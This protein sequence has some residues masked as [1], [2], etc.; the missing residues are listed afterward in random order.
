MMG[1]GRDI[2]GARRAVKDFDIE[3]ILTDGR[4]YSCHSFVLDASRYGEDTVKKLLQGEP[5]NVW[6]PTGISSYE[7]GLND[8]R[9]FVDETPT[10]KLT[11]IDSFMYNFARNI[12]TRTHMFGTVELIEGFYMMFDSVFDIIN[13]V[14]EKDSIRMS[15]YYNEM[16]RFPNYSL[17]SRGLSSQEALK[18]F[19]S[20]RDD[21]IMWQSEKLGIT[22]NF[23]CNS[24]DEAEGIIIKIDQFIKDFMRE[25]KKDPE[26]YGSVEVLERK[27]EALDKFW[28]ILQGKHYKGVP[29]STINYPPDYSFGEKTYAMVAKE[30][31]PL[32]PYL[33]LLCIRDAYEDWRGKQLNKDKG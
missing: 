16:S 13:G 11:R 8:I 27:W 28:F 33:E 30:R 21:Y 26:K 18:D 7:E 9:R 14:E 4:Y 12:K 10:E 24:D 20:L 17:D 5:V 31:N 1:T 29:F 19:M 22:E 2:A 15:D 25:S 3:G 23:F 6:S 32:N